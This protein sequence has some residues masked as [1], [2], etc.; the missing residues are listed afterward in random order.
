MAKYEIIALV[1]LVILVLIVGGKKLPELARGVGQAGKEL[2]KGFREGEEE[3]EK[4][5]K[6]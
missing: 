2:K 6:K 1:V 4:K 3:D 5:T